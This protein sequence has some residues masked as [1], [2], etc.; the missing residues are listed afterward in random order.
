M[1][2]FEETKLNDAEPLTMTLNGKVYQDGKLYMS[3]DGHVGWFRCG[4]NGEN[5]DR[6]LLESLDPLQPHQFCEFGFVVEIKPEDLGTITD[7]PVE[8]IEGEWY[9]CHWEIQTGNETCE[10]VEKPLLYKNGF[11]DAPINALL[12]TPLYRMGKV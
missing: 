2:T 5:F 8:L 7:A 12:F 10:H 9:M 11:K 4:L 1:K 3:K 6:I